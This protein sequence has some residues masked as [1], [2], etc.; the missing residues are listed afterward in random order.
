MRLLFRCP[1]RPGCN[2]LTS[3]DMKEPAMPTEYT[4]PGADYRTRLPAMLS[5]TFTGPRGE[6]CFTSTDRRW[7]WRLEGFLAVHGT[8]DTHRQM[9][10]DLQIYLH[11]TCEHH[12]LGYEGDSDEGGIRAH[13]Q[14]LWCNDVIWVDGPTA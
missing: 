2:R 4:H 9:A 12:W 5:D 14:C 6:P 7:L 3:T 13:R 1:P 10:A 8:N 11:E